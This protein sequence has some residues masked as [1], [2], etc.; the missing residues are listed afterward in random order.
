[1]RA[2]DEALTGARLP[3]ETVLIPFE[4]IAREST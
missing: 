3:P 1:M 2:I 4:I